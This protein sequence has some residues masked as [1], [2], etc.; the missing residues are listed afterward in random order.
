MT[1]NSA[2]VRCRG[3]ELVVVEKAVEPIARI[4][5]GCLGLYSDSQEVT[6][7]RGFGGARRRITIYLAVGSVVRAAR[8]A[9]A[10][11]VEPSAIVAKAAAHPIAPPAPPNR[12]SAMPTATGPANAA[13]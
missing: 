13:V 4:S 9:H 11:A 5:R 3:R 8:I 2:P 6:P 12:S 10:A 1:G 7:P